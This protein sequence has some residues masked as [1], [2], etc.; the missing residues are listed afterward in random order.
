MNGFLKKIL[1]T[2]KRFEHMDTPKFWMK[3]LYNI[4]I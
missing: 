3:H 2:I 1:A 4:D